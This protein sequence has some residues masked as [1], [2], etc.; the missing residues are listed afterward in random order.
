MKYRTRFTAFFFTMIIFD[1]AANFAHPV[2]PTVIQD[3]N[4]HDYM[5]GVALA[6][7]MFTNFLLSPFWGK[8]NNYISS[9][10]SLLICCCGYGVAQLW[11]AFST[12]EL[13][14]ILA[15][16][17]AGLFT[18]GIFVSFLTYV[19]NVARP[20]DQGKFLTYTATIKSVASAFGYMI[21][22]FLGEIS[23]RLSFLAQAV[24][25][26]AV[27]FLFFVICQPDSSTS[28]REVSPKQLAKEANPFQAFIDSRHFM[29]MAFVFLFA[30]NILTN[31]GNTGFDQAFNYYLKDALGLTSSYNGIVKAL[32][33]LI[34]F[35]A[36]MTLCIW[37]IN[38]TKVRRSL[39]VIVLVC[40]LSALGVTVFSNIV[41]FIAFSVLVY[42]GYSVS[43]PVLQSMVAG[44]A[45]PA[46]KNLVM[47][48]FNATQSLGSIAGSLTAGF[49]YSLH[50]KVP[51]ACTAVIYAL[52]TLAAL[53]YVRLGKRA[54][55]AA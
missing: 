50:A 9:R 39:V 52:G 17:F 25:L 43:V 8:I 33:G 26:I 42:A 32:V 27:A 1:L 41:L 47:G 54:G 29:S 46:Q 6:A 20:E 11:F 7:M 12:T 44:R 48:F 28:L 3:L 5:F 30:V 24:T 23:V 13:M 10:T 34:S 40:T 49:I 38:R 22:G 19:V 2:T 36:N 14:I 37:I 4:L 15:R 18:G 21:G 51:F 53:G 55:K 31:F 45:T 16:M 35:A